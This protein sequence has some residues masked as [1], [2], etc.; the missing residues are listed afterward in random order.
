MLEFI[1]KN[2][3]VSRCSHFGS[4]G[5]CRFQTT[6]YE[7]QLA[8]KEAFTK[9]L[10]EGIE[11]K[12]FPILSCDSPWFYRNKMEFSFSQSKKGEKFFGLMMRKKR[13]K[14]VNLNE[15]YLTSS[16]FTAVLNSVRQWWLASDLAAYYPPTGLGLLRT[17]TIRE[18]IRTQEKMVVLTVSGLASFSSNYIDAFKEAILKI[19]T[20]HALILRKQITVKGVPTRFEEEVLYG[21]HYIHEK[22]FD[23]KGR[24]LSFKVRPASFFQPNTLQAEKLY[25]QAL[26]LA[27]L[28][29]TDVLGDLYCGTGT[30][31]ISAASTVKHVIGIEL[32]PDAVFDARDNIV[33][34]NISNMEVWEGDVGLGFPIMHHRLSTVI[35][36]PPRAGLSSQAL[37][38]VLHLEALKVIYI[39][40]NPVT[41]AE[42]V[43]EFLKNGYISTHFQPI[44][45]F[46]HTPHIEN[47]V[48]L[49]K[50]K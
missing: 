23:R 48:I 7:D 28:C 8:E 24:S 29:E 18:G 21:N 45:Q 31:G 5:G 10:F 11:G 38:N 44:D 9:K 49:R 2:E 35:V 3:G 4:C 12:W 25:A 26:T 13:G 39:S 32:N 16:W 22:L 27:E 19:I 36:D 20:P 50:N 33:A 47:I 42:N 30:I 6:P 17:L 34:N 15:C 46:P 40:C 37:K 41:Q 1:E 43:R 14:V